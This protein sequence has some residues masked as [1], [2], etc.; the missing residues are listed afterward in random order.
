MPKVFYCICGDAD[1]E[2]YQ[3]TGKLCR[4]YLRIKRDDK[5]T[6]IKTPYWICPICYMVHQDPDS[7]E[8]FG[9]EVPL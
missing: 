9:F 4:A 8:D 6:W 7:E 5:T 2:K 1:E 3:R